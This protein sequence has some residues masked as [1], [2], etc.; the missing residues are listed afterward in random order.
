MAYRP[1]AKFMNT[2]KTAVPLFPCLLIEKL[3]DGSISLWMLGA[4]LSAP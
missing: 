4:L 1:T 2:N 3:G